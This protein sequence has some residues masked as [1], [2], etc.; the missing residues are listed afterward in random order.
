MHR[1]CARHLTLQRFVNHNTYHMRQK[2]PDIIELDSKRCIHKWLETTL[3]D[4]SLYLQNI[5][6]KY[7]T[8][9]CVAFRAMDVLLFLHKT[10]NLIEM[11]IHIGLGCIHMPYPCH[12]L[13]AQSQAVSFFQNTKKHL[14]KIKCKRIAMISTCR[15]YR[16]VFV[17]YVLHR[18]NDLH[19]VCN[20]S[21]MRR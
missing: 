12:V 7:H 10:Q 21:E 11:L 1:I 17:G 16:F 9:C 6:P 13:C 4:D 15:S 20:R 18:T 8:L 14:K 3:H 2:S 5:L 19:V